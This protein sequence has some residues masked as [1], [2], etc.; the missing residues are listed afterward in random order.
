MSEPLLT[1]TYASGHVSDRDDART[2]H[3][4][5]AFVAAVN[6]GDL[7]DAIGQLAPGALHHGRVSNYRPEGVRL[8]F[9]MLRDVF[10]DLQM[11]IGDQQIDGH[12]VISRIVATGTH[13][14]SFLGKPA[15][16]EPMVW[17][18]VDIAEIET[19]AACGRIVKRYWD[20]WGDPALWTK[21]G[22]IP[23]AMC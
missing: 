14:G 18:S 7:D 2:A 10:P 8:L 20:V 5:H 13:T 19:D 6:R 15:T 1:T 3:A 23:A 21:I 4:V 12:R 17:Q 16:G 22:F 9:S 11:T